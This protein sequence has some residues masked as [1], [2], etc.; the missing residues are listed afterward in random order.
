MVRKLNISGLEK[1]IANNSVVMYYAPWCVYCQEFGPELEKVADMAAKVGGV[2]VV[3]FN[4][5]KHA[6]EV[7]TKQLGADRFGVPVSSDVAGFPSVIMYKKDGSRSLYDGPREAK[8]IMNTIKE[9][10]ELE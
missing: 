4:M 10:Y 9:Y 2:N 5:D 3:R 8:T 1:A 7:R 6:A